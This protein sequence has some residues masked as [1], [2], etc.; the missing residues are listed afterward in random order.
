[1]KSKFGQ[2]IFTRVHHD[3]QIKYSYPKSKVFTIHAFSYKLE[4]TREFGKNTLFRV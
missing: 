3:C 4:L 2:D 1:M